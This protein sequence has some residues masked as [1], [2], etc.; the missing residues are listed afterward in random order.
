MSSGL[1]KC[2]VLGISITKINRLQLTEHVTLPLDISKGINPSMSHSIRELTLAIAS[3]FAPA[4]VQCNVVW[5]MIG[6]VWCGVV[7]CSVV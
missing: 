1:F 3:A 6:V 7:Q 5:T 4:F 2:W